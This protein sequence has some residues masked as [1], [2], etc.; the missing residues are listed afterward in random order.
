M[1]RVAGVIVGA[2][3]RRTHTR[4]GATGAPKYLRRNDLGPTP[5]VDRRTMEGHLRVSEWRD[6]V[7]QLDGRL[8]QRLVYAPSRPKGQICSRGL[9]EC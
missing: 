7:S 9:P 3:E 1:H 2:E 5:I 4:V 8:H 6:R